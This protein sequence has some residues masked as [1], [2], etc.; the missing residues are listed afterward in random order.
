MRSLR[1]FAGISQVLPPHLRYHRGVSMSLGIGSRVGPYEIV[2]W[3]GAGGMG[4]VYRARDP[5]LDRDVAVKLISE[6]LASDP[7]RL[8]RFEHEARAAGQL[9]HP[10]VLVVYDVGTHAGGPYIVSELLEGESLRSRL[11][12]TSLPWRKAVE[13]ARQ[14]ADGLAAAHDKNIVHR[15]VKPDNLFVTSSGPL[16]ILDFGIAK[17]TQPADETVPPIGA[18]TDTV[19]GKV[20]GTAAYMSPEQVRGESIDARSDIFSLGAVLYEM[21]TGQPAFERPTPAE[22]AAAILKED[23]EGGLPPRTPPALERIVSR[24]LEKS[25]TARFQSARDLAFALECLPATGSVDAVQDRPARPSRSASWS[26]LLAGLAA[27]GAIAALLLGGFRPAADDDPL[28]DAQFSLFTN[29]EGTEEGAE[30]SPDGKLVA[31]LSDLEGEFDLWVSQVGTGFFHNLT[32]DLPPLAGSGSIVRKLG[33]SADSSELWFNPADGEPLMRMPWAGGRPRPFLP[34]GAN[35][36][37]WSADGRIVYVHKPDRDDPIYAM[38][39]TGT[40]VSQIMAPGPLKNL[41]PVWSPD[42]QWIYFVRG[43]EPQDETEMDVWRLRPSGGSPERVTNQHLAI[44]F[45]APLDPRRLLYVAR[46]EDRSG[47]WLWTLD[48]TTGQSRRVSAGVD[49]YTSISVSRD[50]RRAVASVANPDSTLW[51]VPLLGGVAEESDARP[52]QLPEP[53]GMAFAPRVSG[54]DL[55]YLSARGARDGL[56]AIRD[57]KASEVRRTIDGAISEP[58]AVS[59]DG[60][61]LAVPIRR[62]G[63]RHLSIMSADG[64]SAQRLAPSIEVD[65]AAGQGGVDWS[66][67]G[68]RIV[69][70]GRDSSGSALFVIEVQTGQVTRLVDGTWVNPVWSPKH[71][72]IVYA[73]RSVIGQVELRAVRPDGTPVTLPNVM[74]RP[75]GYR[76]MRDGSGLV[77]LPRIQ[78]LDFWLFD[79]ATGETRPLTRLANRGA[80]RTFDVTT[81]GQSVIFDRSRQNGNVVMIELPR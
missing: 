2:E 57:G 14:V 47:P 21:L 29:W 32:R 5:R 69:V 70:G 31:F 55:F 33:F 79:F 62:A 50:G 63:R 51:T 23:P 52:Y 7:G 61:R 36:P 11:Q 60:S 4:E 10:N 40:D 20:V 46:A 77:Y 49:Q 64:T 28:R 73:G 8:H 17:L 42:S 12:G 35:T 30:I 27:G 68:T 39:P 41:N 65:G 45:L 18:R 34:K 59:P 58:P 71:D 13:Y 22:T 43:D 6:T 75:G 54:N 25:R 3:L 1:G 66:P 19:P 15:D 78:G 76:F 81:D 80:I 38:D 26:M 53:T 48:V 67:D 24:C 72:L 44:N 16:K 74:V 37:S 56:W 9:N